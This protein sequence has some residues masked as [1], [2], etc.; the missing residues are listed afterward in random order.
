[1]HI[2]TIVQWKEIIHPRLL[3]FFLIVPIWNIP[4]PPINIYLL[5]FFKPN[6]ILRAKWAMEPNSL[7]RSI[8][9]YFFFYLTKYGLNNKYSRILNKWTLFL[10]HASL[11]WDSAV[12]NFYEK[13][14]LNATLIHEFA[15]LGICP[16]Q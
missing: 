5:I 7:F 1:M 16:I 3:K 10:I 15:K 13:F 11:Y 6:H 8:R 2:C 4:Y 14:Q 9:F 12:L